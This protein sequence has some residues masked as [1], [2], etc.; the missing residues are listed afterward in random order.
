M[1][2]DSSTRSERIVRLERY[3]DISWIQLFSKRLTNLNVETYVSHMFTR[4]C[5][6]WVNSTRSVRDWCT[7]NQTRG[8]DS[9]MV[10][11]QLS[12]VGCRWPTFVNRCQPDNRGSVF[13]ILT[14][15]RPNHTILPQL[16][17]RFAKITN[18]NQ[19]VLS[20]IVESTTL[21]TLRPLI[22]IFR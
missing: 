2:G 21:R 15:T 3:L 16:V 18:L 11:T 14:W 4:A 10:P 6:W 5:V 8:R 20:R 17:S 9:P 19:V 7:V 12:A 22:N 13:Q 1:E